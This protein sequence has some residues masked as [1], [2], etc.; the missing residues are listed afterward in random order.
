MDRTYSDCVDIIDEVEKIEQV[1]I[2]DN[3]I[4]KMLLLFIIIN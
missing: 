3:K 4:K 2:T 1:V